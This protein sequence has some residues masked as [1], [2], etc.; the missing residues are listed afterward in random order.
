MKSEE[1]NIPVIGMT[2]AHPLNIRP[3]QYPFMLNGNIMTDINSA[4]TLTN[5]NSNYLCNNLP[6][7]FVVIGTMY[8]HEDSV[9]YLW[10]VNPTTNASQIGYL[11]EYKF[12]DVKDPNIPNN[13]DECIKKR[14]EAPPLETTV[15][16]QLCAYT[17]IVTDGPCS[18]GLSIDFPVRKGVFKKD[19]CGDSIYFTDFLNPTRVLKLKPGTHLPD[20]TQRYVTGQTS[21]PCVEPIY[22]TDPTHVDCNAIRLFPATSQI[23]VTPDSIGVGGTLKAGTYQLG[24]CYSDKNGQR[25]TRTFS[26]SNPVS[27]FDLN[28]TVTDQ[29]DYPTDKA[30]RFILTNLDNTN[31]KFIDIFVISTNAGVATIREFDTID[32][33]SVSNGTLQ[34]VLSDFTQGTPATIDDV[35]QVFPV[36]DK[37]Q[38]ITEAGNCL[39]L[40]NLTS[41]PDLN[42]QRAFVYLSPFFQW[43]SYE[44][45]EALYADGAAAADLRTFLRDELYTFGIVLERN[46]TLDTCVYPL[47]GRAINTII[48]KDCVSGY[49]YYGYWL[50]DGPTTGVFPNKA[51]VTFNNVSYVNTSGSPTTPSQVP[52]TSGPW[53]LVTSDNASTYCIIPDDTAL[54]VNEA[55]VFSFPGCAEVPTSLPK[56]QVYNTAYNRGVTCGYDPTSVNCIQKVDT[57]VCQ[58]FTYTDGDTV[59]NDCYVSE[60]NQSVTC[61]DNY[62]TPYN[63]GSV[64]PEEGCAANPDPTIIDPGCHA[65]FVR[66]SLDAASS[67]NPLCIDSQLQ[68]YPTNLS[69]PYTIRRSSVEK[70]VL[71]SSTANYYVYSLS[72]LITGIPNAVDPTPSLSGGSFSG[73]VDATISGIHRSTWLWYNINMPGTNPT[74]YLWPNQLGI[75]VIPTSSC[76]YYSS[77]QAMPNYPLYFLGDNLATPADYT[78]P[79]GVECLGATWGGDYWNLG[80]QVIEPGT[81]EVND[82]IY[83]S[84]WYSFTGSA[85]TPTAVIKVK[86]FYSDGTAFAAGDVRIDVYEGVPNL[87]AGPKYSTGTDTVA[88]A[89]FKY[90]TAGNVDTGVLIVGDVADSTGDTPGELPLIPGTQY[91]V[92]IYLLAPGYA[93]LNS[94]PAP[95]EPAHLSN[96][97]CPCYLPNY[98]WANL[99][100]NY[101]ATSNTVP[102]TTPAV[103]QLVCTYDVYYRVNE[104]EGSGCLVKPFEFGDFA[105]WEAATKTY[106]TSLDSA[107]NPLWGPL[108]GRSIRH[109]KF[110]DCLVSY[111]QDQDPQ[112]NG[113]LGSITDYPF[114]SGRTANIYPI[115]LKINSE[116]VKT[117]LTWAVTSGLISQAE[118]DSIT[119]YKIV[120]GNRATNKSIAAKGLLTD[121]WNY[122]EY[123]WVSNHYSQY[124]TYFS[125]YP[126]NNI[127]DNDPYLNRGGS[128]FRPPLAGIANTRYT[129]HS[130]DTSFNNPTVGTELK[131]EAGVF[132]AA[133]GNFYQV[134]DHPKY[135][136]IS[137]NGIV[138]A[139]I[140]AGIELAADLT[141][142][143]GQAIGT[144]IFGLVDSV[145]VGGIMVA[146]GEALNA[147]PNFFTYAQRWEQI[148]TDFG[149][150]QNFAYY[151]AAVGNYHSSGILGAIPNSGNKRRLISNGTYLVGGNLSINES[152]NLSKINNYQRE[153]SIYLHTNS[154]LN[155]VGTAINDSILRDTS[156]FIMSQSPAFQ[157]LASITQTDPNTCGLVERK[158]QVAANYASMKYYLPDQYGAL[159]D[160]EWLY[161]GVFETL[162]FNVTQ[163]T[164]CDIMLGGD[165]FLTR[166]TKYIKI[167]FFLDNPVGVVTGVDFQYHRISNITNSTYYFNSVG[168]TALNSSTI[169]F[170]EVEHNFDC[171]STGSGMYLKGNMYLFS[172]GIMSF[173]CESDFNL[174]Y[175]RCTNVATTRCFYPYQSDVQNATQEYLVPIETPNNYLYNRDYSKQNK[176][177]FFCSQPII[178]HNQPCVTT[179]RNR[180]AYSIPDEDPD[181]YRDN[182]RI[183]LGA[184]KFDF[185]LYYGF[186]NGVDGIERDRVMIRLTDTTLVFNAS[187]RMETD[188]GSVQLGTASLFAQKPEQEIKTDVGFGGTESHA[189]ISTPLGHFWVDTERHKV[190]LLPPQKRSAVAENNPVPISESFDTFFR[191]NLPFFISQNF[192]TFNIDNPYKDVGICMDWD[193]KYGRLFLTKLDYQLRSEWVGQVTYEDDG[194]GRGGSFFV[195]ETEISLTDTTYFCNKSWTISYS[196]GLKAWISFYSFIPNYY[197]G[198]ARYL[199]TGVNFV[200]PG[201]DMIGVWNHFISNKSYQVFYG[202]LYPFISDVIVPEKLYNQQLHSLEYQ[203]DF[204]RFQ[205]DFD[206]YYNPDHTFNK[207]V[208]WTENQN[209]GDLILVPQKKGDFSQTLK[210]PIFGPNATTILVTRQ[211]HNWRVNQFCD[212]VANKHNNVPP[213][214]YGCSPFMKQVNPEAINYNK[215]TFQRQH[216]T[217]DY[218]TLR[219]NNDIYSNYKIINKWFFNNAMKSYS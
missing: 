137:D 193:Y 218:F 26:V 156:K 200:R 160:I 190:F 60:I 54:D 119:G 123:D 181:F 202:I 185:P 57:L 95:N 5:E 167:P 145:P 188:A 14:A 135:I 105:Y 118:R 51:V 78:D 88:P 42:L 40:G 12:V 150:P 77:P 143:I 183:F 2:D 180:V 25:A 84:Y 116:D 170:A 203:A 113:A 158:S 176:E 3:N 97:N 139:S 144:Q 71:P 70:T 92:H 148:I 30:I 172:Y 149:V 159:Q 73:C 36:Y 109:F 140:L 31:Y 166:F 108:C 201:A 120:R 152:G 50:A 17:P 122:N 47:V 16:P 58:S 111:F 66:S 196:P 62:P 59:P 171:D 21:A 19:N 207:M 125:N 69:N 76:I 147:V 133:L 163:N 8:V 161:T 103:K 215:P 165:T 219:F 91:Y 6:D 173:I 141:V 126:F 55:D 199:Q 41:P 128:A 114:N 79:S 72:D 124:T 211:T 49:Q 45:T 182:W 194:S 11:S 206:Y 13:C 131:L 198:H 154:L 10:L 53:T 18:L 43:K 68:L 102:I 212:L 61:A 136:L 191:N 52:G 186:L 189:F 24:A 155:Y 138:L 217:S 205:N 177:N 121:M 162:N 169:Q 192:P 34:Y 37:A 129:L 23:H 112:I 15:Q 187:Y 96:T 28:Q 209:S 93:K 83:Q 213:M 130:P 94:A 174:N 107:G 204:L 46:N 63:D 157:T 195:G 39:L 175:R 65:G 74:N 101:P 134:L 106:P 48:D 82:T 80:G 86:L 100:V 142:I 85:G 104:V 29:V 197:I 32:I 115:G 98:S 117:W 67:A 7:G 56:W 27:V 132:G 146:V 87:G 75:N 127:T 99:C 4:V 35:L 89:T 44:S 153:D 184:N 64:E 216:M 33:S 110:P 22:D 38:E 208:I 1:P 90:T 151:Y 214:I 168:E 179:Y 210:Y 178:Y 20:N 164:N 81:G 9:V